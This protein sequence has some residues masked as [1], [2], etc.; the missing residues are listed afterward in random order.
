MVGS[1]MSGIPGRGD[2]GFLLVI[3]GEDT[4]RIHTHRDSGS[5]HWVEDQ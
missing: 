1:E 2:F 3:L 5:T 4:L